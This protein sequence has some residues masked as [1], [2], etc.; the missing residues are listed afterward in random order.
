MAQPFGCLAR[1]IG[2]HGGTPSGRR[3]QAQAGIQIAP[4]EHHHD[5]FRCAAGGGAQTVFDIAVEAR[6]HF[7]IVTG[8]A[9]SGVG[10]QVGGQVQRGK[11]A[12]QVKLAPRAAR[13]RGPL[14]DLHGLA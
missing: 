4:F 1:D 10:A 6:D 14:I 7:D 3:A 9:G 5:A 13:G 11:P 8:K 12:N 2:D